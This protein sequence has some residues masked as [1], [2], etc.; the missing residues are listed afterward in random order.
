MFRIFF[1]AS[2][3]TLIHRFYN[4]RS[5]GGSIA[6]SELTIGSFQGLQHRAAEMLAMEAILDVGDDVLEAGGAA[7]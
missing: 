6:E 4:L 7:Q 5:T 1:P 3:R 2:Y